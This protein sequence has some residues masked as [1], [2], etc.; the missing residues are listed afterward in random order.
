VT[1]ESALPIR[2]ASKTP[3]A[4]VYANHYVIGIDGVPSGNHS[5]DVLR[6]FAT[7]RSGGAQGWR[8]A[9]ASARGRVRTSAVYEFAFLRTAAPI[10]VDTKAV[11]FEMNVG[12]WTL[13]SKFKPKQ[14]L[15]RGELAV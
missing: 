3:M 15:Y 14:M 5:A 11:A 8:V 9:A 6:Q 1:W 4:P 7:L 13:Q 2:Q 10:G 12:H